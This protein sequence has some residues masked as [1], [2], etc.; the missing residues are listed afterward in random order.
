MIDLLFIPAMAVINRLRG[1]GIPGRWLPSRSVVWWGLALLLV[2]L[3]T[4]DALTAIVIGVSY[5]FWGVFGWGEYLD[6]SEAENSPEDPVTD[7]VLERLGWMEDP[8]THDLFGA[9][10]RFA[11]PTLILTNYAW[12]VLGVF[13]S[14]VFGLTASYIGRLVTD[15]TGWAKQEYT[16]GALWGLLIFGAL[17]YA[18]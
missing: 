9:A 8:K 13:I 7:Y 15:H 1:E 6:H 2:C 14:A 10:I 5:A 16:T 3:T 17:T 12:P 18:L 4:T 11:W